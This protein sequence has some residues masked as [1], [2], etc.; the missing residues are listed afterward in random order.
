MNLDDVIGIVLTALGIAYLL[1]A[2]LR[3]EKF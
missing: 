2:M 3:P 1:F